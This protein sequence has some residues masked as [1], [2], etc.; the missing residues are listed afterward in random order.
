MSNYFFF[1]VKQFAVKTRSV[2]TL[3]QF[4]VDSTT[5]ADS[6][7]PVYIAAGDIRKRLSEHFTAPKSK[8]EVP[9]ISEVIKAMFIKANKPFLTYHESFS[10]LQ[11][12]NLM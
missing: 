12:K 4:S 8:F 2:D 7:E 9:V 11:M 5:S 6:K 1:L 10:L 3:S